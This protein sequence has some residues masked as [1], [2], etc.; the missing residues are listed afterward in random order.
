M[1]A[2]L[3]SRYDVL[4]LVAHDLKAPLVSLQWQVQLLLRGAR[5]GRIAGDQL[6]AALEAISASAA[7]AVSAIDELHALTVV[8]DV[9]PEDFNF[10]GVLQSRPI[11][12]V[13]LVEQIVAGWPR[14]D[15]YHFRLETDGAALIVNGDVVRLRRVVSNLVDNAV[16][17]SPTSREIR[18]RL[19]RAQHDG[20][21]YAQLAVADRGVGIPCDHLEHVFERFWRGHV[22][23]GVDGQ[24]LGLA[25]VRALVQAHGGHVDV[26]SQVGNGSTFRV[27]LPL[28]L[29]A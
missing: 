22:V 8:E 2:A 6:E 25:S 15:E 17:Y 14:A 20:Q 16:K 3:E 26:E 5:A 12:L 13:E 28:A 29:A 1:S 24:G 10:N 18:V 4:Q 7:E 21:V 27:W 9:G 23:H 19:G 11:D